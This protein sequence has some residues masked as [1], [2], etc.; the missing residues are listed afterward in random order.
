M[1]LST[2]QVVPTSIERSWDGPVD[3]VGSVE[4]VGSVGI[5]AT[6]SPVLIGPVAAGC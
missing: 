6:V 5:V 3:P 2:I 4:S 1:K